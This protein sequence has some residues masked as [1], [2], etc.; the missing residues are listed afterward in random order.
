MRWRYAGGI[1]VSFVLWGTLPL[2]ASEELALA[3]KPASPQP[4]ISLR[5]LNDAA[6]SLDHLAQRYRTPQQIATFLQRHF[7]FRRDDELFGE[8]EHWQSPEEFLARR[9]G[10]CEDYALLAREFLSRNDIEAYVFSLFGEDGYAHTVCIFRDAHGRYNLLNQD[11]L[12]LYRA[13]SL[14][15]LATALHAGWTWGGITDQAGRRGRLVKEIINASPHVTVREQEFDDV[16]T[17]L[18]F[19][20]P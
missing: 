15:A 18:N 4:L 13:Q 5:E 16:L 8:I 17:G 2:S 20:S 12:R 14:E 9:S 19:S 6:L 10:D 1:L 7:T 3:T 11:K